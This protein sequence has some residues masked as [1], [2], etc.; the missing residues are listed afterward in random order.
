MAPRSDLQ[1]LYGEG[2]GG[3][4]PDP[5]FPT[6]NVLWVLRVTATILENCN[7][8]HLYQS[9]EVSDGCCAGGARWRQG[10]QMRGRNRVM[11]ASSRRQGSALSRSGANGE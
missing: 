2:E 7:N 4:E 11:C 8:K 5:P 9:Y 6:R 1:L 3:D 10:R